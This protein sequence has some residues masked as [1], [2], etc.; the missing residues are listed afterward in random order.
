MDEKALTPQ[1]VYAEYEEG[2][3]FNEGIKLYETV[4]TN[5]N[6]FIGK[7]WEGV[8]SNGLPTPTI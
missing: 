8:R 4:E 2:V 5:E 1:R 7:Q 3:Q 6:F